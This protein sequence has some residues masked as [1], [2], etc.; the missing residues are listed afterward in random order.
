MM[1]A[2]RLEKAESCL[3]VGSGL[4]KKTYYA[5]GPHYFR[6]ISLWSGGF[7]NLTIL[8]LLLLAFFPFVSVLMSR[9]GTISSN[10]KRENFEMEEPNETWMKLE[11]PVVQVIVLSWVKI[12]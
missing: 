12:V 10:R 7:I 2:L 1:N 11:E 8:E 4:V 5:V 3:C 9:P 6:R